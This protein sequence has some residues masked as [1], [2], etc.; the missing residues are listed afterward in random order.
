MWCLITGCGASS[1]DVVPHHWMIG[2][3]SL[4]VVPHHWMIGAPRLVVAQLSHI[5][6]K[7]KI[8]P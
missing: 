8:P 5:K 4:D 3:S 6:V 2:A 7:Y 1:L